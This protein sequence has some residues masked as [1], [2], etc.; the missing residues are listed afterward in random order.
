MFR[1]HQRS[2]F[3]TT[4]SLR[5]S[6]VPEQTRF[7]PHLVK[8]KGT[9]WQRQR[10]G[11]SVSRRSGTLWSQCQSESQRKRTGTHKP[12][13]KGEPH[14]P[15]R[16][17][18]KRG[19]AG[20]SPRTP[21]TP[22]EKAKTRKTR[23]QHVD[24]SDQD[25]AGDR[26]EKTGRPE[27]G[28]GHRWRSQGGARRRRDT[29]QETPRTTGGKTGT[30]QTPRTVGATG[31][32][33]TPTDGRTGVKSKTSDTRGGVST[34]LTPA[35]VSKSRPRSQSEHQTSSDDRITNE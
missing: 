32:R 23:R 5:R 31:K 10:Q 11:R 7:C 22:R 27:G 25:N 17:R 28:S 9:V 14:G 24:K 20:K 1:P 13:R 34:T 6:G 16:K 3:Q 30:G 12:G 26:A 19:G 33:V 35:S 21:K 18:R 2:K 15:P 4:V 8:G 29:Q